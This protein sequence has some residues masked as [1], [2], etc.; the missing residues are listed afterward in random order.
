MKSKD[1][2]LFTL[3]LI[4]HQYGSTRNC[5]SMRLKYLNCDSGSEQL[6]TSFLMYCRLNDIYLLSS[7]PCKHQQ[8]FI[9]CLW[10]P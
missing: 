10:E 4:I 8:N 1:E 3:K 9:E 6:E 7:A 2:L 5:Q